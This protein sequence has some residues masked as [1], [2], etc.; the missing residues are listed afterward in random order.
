MQ[1]MGAKPMG[2]RCGKYSAG[3][4]DWT[5]RDLELLDKRQDKYYYVMVC[6]IH[7]LTLLAC[8]WKDSKEEE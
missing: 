8:I 4:F 5:R 3:I 6:F 7:V 1:E 2:V